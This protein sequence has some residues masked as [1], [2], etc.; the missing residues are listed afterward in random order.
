[1]SS[2]VGVGTISN[3]AIVAIARLLDGIRTRRWLAGAS[4]R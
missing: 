1:L 4:A 2:C 3:V